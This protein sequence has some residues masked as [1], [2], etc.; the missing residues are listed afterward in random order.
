MYLGLFNFLGSIQILGPY[1]NMVIRMAWASVSFL[2]IILIVLIPSG[3]A[4]Q[5]L[6]YPHRVAPAKTI[7]EIF[8]FD[9]YRLFGELNLGIMKGAFLIFLC[10]HVRRLFGPKQFR[11]KVYL[12]R[13]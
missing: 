2:I 9:Y 12:N 1:L 10:L 13:L 6:L 11:W 5:A 7:K 8:F 4:Q 3:I